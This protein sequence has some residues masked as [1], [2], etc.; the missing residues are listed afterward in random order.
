[1]YRKRTVIWPFTTQLY[2]L[3]QKLP[4][5]YSFDILT[6]LFKRKTLRPDGIF[7][8]IKDKLLRMNTDLPFYL[9]QNY[10]RV[11][12]Q[13]ENYVRD[14]YK[15]LNLY[16]TK[17]RIEIRFI[18]IIERIKN[19]HELTDEQAQILY[20][21]EI[22]AELESVEAKSDKLKILYSLLDKYQDVILVSDMYLPKEVILKMLNKVDPKL[23]ELPLYL[24]SEI[25]KIKI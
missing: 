21:L 23:T 7:F 15:N 8:Y 25:G 6:L 2:G 5:L 16:V 1:M 12:I 24:S 9:I 22:E 18:D 14:Y 19:I 4:N 13:A 17:K 20:D 11:R 10:P 3:Y